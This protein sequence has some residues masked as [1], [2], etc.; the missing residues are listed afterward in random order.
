MIMSTMNLKELITFA[1]AQAETIF[2]RTGELLP[3]W[4]CIKSNGE[5][6]IVPSPCEDKDMAVGLIKALMELEDVETYVFMSEAWI[7][8]R[9]QGD[10]I[11]MADRYGL[12]G[13]PDR[14]E[15]IM[16][17][18]ENRNGE[19]QTA[20]RYILRPEHGKAKL[21]P[22]VLDD[23]TQIG[24]SSGRMVGMLQRRRPQ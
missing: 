7:L 14:R 22:L 4:H 19:E 10:D 8:E 9:A 13:H 2:R 12:S 21:S 17:A 18:A 3:M 16:F 1:S 24:Q 23:M 11:A 5:Q 6:L 15:V 20:R